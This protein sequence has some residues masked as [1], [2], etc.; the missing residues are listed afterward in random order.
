M[1]SGEYIW[2]DA[3]RRGI[4]LALFT[5]PEGI[6]Q[7]SWINWKKVNF[8]KL[9]T[10]LGRNFVFNLQTF[11]GFCQV[12]ISILLQIQ[13]ENNFLPISE[14][15][16]GGMCLYDCYTY[17]KHFVFRKCLEMRRHLGSGRKTVNSQGYSELREPIKT[18]ENCYSLIWWKLNSFICMTINLSDLDSMCKIQKNSYFQRK[19]ERLVFT[20][21]KEYIISRHY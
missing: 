13:H 4:Y 11:R 7:I 1:N 5:D 8:Y 16:Q 19:S 14:H 15:R 20:H 3:K 12:H 18:R 6:Y 17:S 2:R 21:I 9:K 10:S